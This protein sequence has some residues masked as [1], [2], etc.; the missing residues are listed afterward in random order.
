MNSS[1]NSNKTYPTKS[2][3]SNLAL[4][5]NPK[6]GS[7]RDTLKSEPNVTNQSAQSKAA[8]SPMQSYSTPVVTNDKL[9]QETQSQRC[10][11]CAKIWKNRKLFWILYFATGR[12]ILK[13]RTATGN[14]HPTRS[15]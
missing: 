13:T 8:W 15:R 3:I 4:P 2:N 6:L 1:L 9:K 14:H 10:M 5:N 11:C 12:H 7:R